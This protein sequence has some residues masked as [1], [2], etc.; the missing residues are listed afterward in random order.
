MENNCYFFFFRF[1]NRSTY[2]YVV[3]ILGVEEKKRKNSLRKTRKDSGYIYNNFRNVV[4]KKNFTQIRVLFLKSKSFFSFIL[5]KESSPSGF[6]LS[7]FFLTHGVFKFHGVLTSNNV[8][9]NDTRNEIELRESP[10]KIH[11][12]LQFRCSILI[13]TNKVPVETFRIV[14]K[15]ISNFFHR[16]F[17]HHLPPFFSQNLPLRKYSNPSNIESGY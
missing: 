7:L 16:F 2:I 3:I 4:T 12:P 11:N 1:N 15:L 17:F 14:Y 13:L 5:L 9:S 10:L 6:L 8:S